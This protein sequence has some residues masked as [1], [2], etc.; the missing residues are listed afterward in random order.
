MDQMIAREVFDGLLDLNRLALSA[1]LF[2]TCYHTLAAAA[3]AAYSASDTESLRRVATLIQA[4]SRI[5]DSAKS[6]I[7][8]DAAH[9]R[10]NV[11]LFTSLTETVRVMLLGLEAAR[12][13]RG[14][15]PQ[16]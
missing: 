16:S 12:S 11:G 5:V 10:G 7:S 1:G 14:S 6:H 3:H 8:N 4:Q 9:A 15:A 13:G 2:E